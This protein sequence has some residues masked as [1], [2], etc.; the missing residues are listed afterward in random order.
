MIGAPL[1]LRQFF[2]DQLHHIRRH[3]ARL[4]RGLLASSRGLVVRLLEAVAAHA[5]VANQLAAD[6]RSIDANLPRDIGLRVAALQEC[7]NLA[8]LFVGQV[9]IAF[10]HY[11]SVRCAVP[12]KNSLH[13][14][15]RKTGIYNMAKSGGRKG[16]PQGCSLR[17]HRLRRLKPLT[18]TFSPAFHSA[19]PVYADLLHF[20]LE[21]AIHNESSWFMT[22]YRRVSAPL[23]QIFAAHPIWC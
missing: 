16:R 10:G 5:G 4:V 23:Q 2:F 6:G 21:T 22:K 14:T 12:R 20:G 19:M 7:V 13:L 8:A 9:E 11:S 15:A 3:F 18:P 17:S 1:L